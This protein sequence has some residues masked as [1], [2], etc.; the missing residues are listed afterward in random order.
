MNAQEMWEQYSTQYNITADYQAWP[1]GADP[2]ELARLVLTGIKTG[3]AS[4]YLWYELE[5]LELPKV[6]DY[7]VVL[8][9]KE[10]AVCIIQTTKVY[11]VP[12][13]EVSE[14]HAYK[15]GE[16]DRSLQYWRRVHEDFFKDE[17]WEAGLTFDY[18]TKVVCEEFARVFP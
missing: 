7:S 14:E 18:Q 17:F 12:F 10:D 15:E 3:T 16:G 13:D 4:A 5:D 6:G 8:N 1:F 11:I 9:S 2:D